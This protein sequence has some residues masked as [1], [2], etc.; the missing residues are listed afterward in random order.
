MAIGAK[1]K[2][3]TI[4]FNGDTTKLGRALKDIDTKTKGVDR[5]LK[6]VNNAMKFNPKNMELVAQKQ[7]LLKQKVDQTRQRLDALKRTQ[8][9]LDDDPA[10]DKTSQDYMEL[11]REI[12]TT[13]SK[14]R[15]FEAEQKKL[16]NAK[17]DQLGEK[18]QQVGGKMQ[19]AGKAMSKY[20][21]A[22]IVGLGALAVKTGADFDTAMS[23]V[24]S[25]SGATGKELD[26][27][28]DKAREMG[29]KTK[30]SASE[31]AEAMNYMAMAGWKTEDMLSG[32]DGIMNLAA[33]SGED[34]ATT[35]DIVTDALTA[36]GL[37]AED[38]G[39]FA[40]VLA[41]ASSNANTNVKMMGETFKYAAPIAGSL[42]YSVEDVAES[43]GLMGNAGI[44]SSQ[45]GTS[46][47]RIMTSLNKDFKITSK[48][49]GETTIK[50]TN[51][52]GSMRS[53][54]DI[55]E[56]T[57]K[58][59]KD[60]SA[61]EQSTAAEAL[62]G[63]NAMS[64]F[65][66]IMNASPKDIKKLEKA[67]G[68]ADGSAE[69]MAETMQD[70]L[71]GQVT[72][73]KSQ[74]S[75]LAISFS[76]LLMPAIRKIVGVVQKFV[77]WLNSLSEGQKKVILTLLTVAAA[78]GPVLIVIGKL[79]T[80]IGAII[81]LLPLIKTAFMALTGPIGIVVAAIAAA[82]AIGIAL[83]KNWDK[84]KAF[85][86]KIWN[87][88]KQAVTTVFNAIKTVIV[89]YWKTVWTITKTIWGTIFNVLKTVWN[90]IKTAASA[91]LKVIVGLFKKA[92]QA[93]KTAWSKVKQF[94]SGIWNG[95]KSVF[96]SVGTWFADKF[97]A[98]ANA[99]RHAFGSIKSF[100]T[101]VWSKI[102]GVF[103]H[104]AGFF[105]NKFSAAWKAIKG[106]FRNVGTFFGGIWDKIKDKFTSIGGKIGSAIKG[107][108]AGAI[109]SVIKLA[110]DAINKAIGIINGAIKVINKVI[111][112]KSADIG[113]VPKVSFP[114]IEWHK[115]GGIFDSPSVIGVGEAGPEAVIPL[116]KF[117]DKLD[118]MSTGGA[119][120]TNNITISGAV[121]PEEYAARLARAIK[122]QLR[123]V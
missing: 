86:I 20:V 21:T 50:T 53:W 18:F 68:N 49:L 30:F 33:A 5:S 108:V 112:G 77:D 3:I 57:R 119:V 64:G 90:A 100:F 82:V 104:V 78:I 97:R 110:E 116:N 13:E 123:T 113:K 54:G 80:G 29:A 93:I 48:T 25:V 67:L 94:F 61:S 87:G 44:K 70:N 73:L 58:A 12:I 36:F 42:G 40:D 63:K 92:W 117:W 31:A 46:L 115:K 69:D 6:Q 107:A 122:L 32:I 14:L 121:N 83:Y 4:E 8:A 81:K 106:V 74:L 95:I 84:V 10:V 43:I 22:P 59:F 1:V 91:V 16:Q 66:A 111:P 28:R 65:L 11:R 55:I 38:S 76:D 47:R 103:G 37:K 109:N 79:A 24:Q 7:T 98:A 19:T 39:H 72:I 45:A 17:F 101:G 89:T 118:S 41:A 23:Q 120:I 60:L 62:V 9:Q 35:S 99:I 34:L 105:K 114:R 102:K 85:L 27:L 75:E 52:D 26:A 15:H 71:A 56:D 51:A 2:G 88:I 96:S